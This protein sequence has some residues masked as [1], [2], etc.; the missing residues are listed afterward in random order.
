MNGEPEVLAFAA[1]RT[2]AV[3]TRWSPTWKPKAARRTSRAI[4]AIHA[5]PDKWGG[6]GL[7]A[8]FQAHIDVPTMPLRKGFVLPPKAPEDEVERVK[9][10]ADRLGFEVH[11]HEDFV[12]RGLKRIAWN[13]SM[14]TAVYGFATVGLLGIRVVK[15]RKGDGLSVAFKKTRRRVGGHSEKQRVMHDAFV[16]SVTIRPRTGRIGTA[17]WTS[18]SAKVFRGGPVVDLVTLAHS[19]G[20]KFSRSLGDLAASLGIVP[21]KHGRTPEALASQVAAIAHCY[22]KLSARHQSL[23]RGTRSPSVVP[24]P[25]AYGQTVMEL[26]GLT[27]PL[28]RPGFLDHDPRIVGTMESYHGAEVVILHRRESVP[29]C[30]YMDVAAQF[31]QLAIHRRD[32]RFLTAKRIEVEDVDPAY[33]EEEINELGEDALTDPRMYRRF[34]M[35]FTNI[36]PRGATLPRRVPNTDGSYRTQV[37]PFTCSEPV[38]FNALDVVRARFED[39]ECPQISSAFRLVPR[40]RVKGLRPFDLSGAGTFDPN[41]PGADLFRFLFEGR[42]RVRSGEAE[43]HTPWSRKVLATTLKAI[44]VAGIGSFA[45]VIPKATR[46]RSVEVAITDGRGERRM[47]RTR[48]PE[49]P[50]DWYCP[51]VAA[52]IL[53]ASRLQGFALRRLVSSEGGRPLY[54]ATDSVVAADLTPDATCRVLEAFER[55]NP[56]ALHGPRVVAGHDGLRVHPN[57]LDGPLALRIVPETLEGKARTDRQGDRYQLAVPVT[58]T[59]WHTMRYILTDPD[60]HP[61]FHSEHGLGDLID[62]DLSLLPEE[63][64]GHALSWTAGLGPEPEGLDRPRL[65]VQAANRPDLSD[66]V[67][68]S[69]LLRAWSPLVLAFE[70]NDLG[71][72]ER[73]LVARWTP[74]FNSARAKWRVFGSGELIRHPELQSIRDYMSRYTRTRERGTLDEQGKASTVGTIGPLTPRPVVAL[75]IRRVGKEA[76]DVGEWRPG[77]STRPVMYEADRVGPTSRSLGDQAFRDA[78]RILGRALSRGE[79]THVY[80]RGKT[81]PHKILEQTL[82]ARVAPPELRRAIIEGAAHLVHVSPAGAADHLATHLA[83]C[84]LEGCTLPAAKGGRWCGTKHRKSAYRQRLV[85]RQEE[86]STSWIAR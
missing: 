27:P 54:S 63:W 2:H 15:S 31:V 69:R 29:G 42:A 24:T 48:R 70:R 39:G 55:F 10:V 40:G 53:A 43:V 56:T 76:H 85:K 46:S 65:V 11:S 59:G 83:V 32:W 78:C 86:G 74:G 3:P 19:Q 26:S 16:P 61:L 13:L 68:S 79:V 12:V 52:G 58:F 21:P 30:T 51:P 41:E 14:A 37:G 50:G 25:G 45:Q 28:S 20:G 66:A 84:D 38:L 67:G 47:V 77:G 36:V 5:Y 4:F 73:M 81:V 9:Q 34:G 23:V 6:L 35:T 33:L 7:A 80:L 22:A 62:E 72:G 64:I 1:G 60:G 8:F 44:A 71:I 57:Y 82:Q 17:K 75:S 49:V 18:T